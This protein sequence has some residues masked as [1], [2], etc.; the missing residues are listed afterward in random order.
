VL[1]SAVRLDVS[2]DPAL[3]EAFQTVDA[4]DDLEIPDQ[5]PT[6]V[7]IDGISSTSSLHPEA[8]ETKTP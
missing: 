4:D 3:C 1:S 8:K 6:E 5:E 2:L 7:P